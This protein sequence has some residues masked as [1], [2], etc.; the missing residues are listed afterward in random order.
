MEE[1]ECRDNIILDCYFAIL[2]P[3]GRSRF[4]T[5]RVIFV[6]NSVRLSVKCQMVSV[7]SLAL[8]HDSSARVETAQYY[9]TV[10][11]R[12]RRTDGRFPPN[13]LFDTE[14]NRKPNIE[15][16]QIAT[17]ASG[18]RMI[19]SYK[20]TTT[21]T[22]LPTRKEFE[23]AHRE[24]STGTCK[25]LENCVVRKAPTLRCCRCCTPCGRT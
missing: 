7:R 8:P 10:V 19:G 21:T 4:S 13:I 12:K 14:E 23:T 5:P 22:M 2:H 15:N 11:Q 24:S 25:D 6:T 17:M 3:H 16:H 9:G 20:P 1:E 18:W